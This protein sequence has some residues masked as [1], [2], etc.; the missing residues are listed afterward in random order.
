MM[1]KADHVFVLHKKVVSEQ[2]EKL[3]FSGRLKTA[4]CVG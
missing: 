2:E 4:L 1:S 3:K